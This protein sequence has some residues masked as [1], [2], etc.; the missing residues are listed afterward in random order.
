MANIWGK[1][2]GGAA[3]FALGG[4]IGA[5]IGALAGHAV[6]S[7]ALAGP[8]EGT[9]Q[10][11]FTIGVIALGAKMA[12]ADGVVTRA[13]I[14]AFKQVFQVPPQESANVARVF[15][16]AK[17][18]VRGFE[19]YA[20]QIAG[21]FPDSPEVL[22]KVLEC[23]VHIARADGKLTDDELIYLHAVANIFGLDAARFARAEAAAG[24]TIDPY[25]VLGVAR[26]A[27]N[28]AIK[29]AWRKLAREN[30]PDTLI[31][32]GMPEEAIALATRQLAAINAAY[33]RVSKERGIK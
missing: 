25:Q 11:A 10:I 8:D 9:K 16:L 28:E 12:K 17:Q 3:G 21:L 22:E 6:D 32:K 14:D 4:P 27:S 18:D 31:A 24:E 23:L 7:L 29:Q 5:L 1:I 15:D 30:H 19:P 33:D 26:D 13:E 20:R 2:V